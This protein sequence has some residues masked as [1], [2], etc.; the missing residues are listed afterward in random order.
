MALWRVAKDLVISLPGDCKAPFIIPEVATPPAAPTAVD[1][2][3]SPPP[4]TSLHELPPATK[5]FWTLPSDPASAACF[6]MFP[7]F[8]PTA[9]VFPIR[10]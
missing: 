3:C 5:T 10:H 1:L 6:A 8:Q 9:C 4:L 2:A 7:V